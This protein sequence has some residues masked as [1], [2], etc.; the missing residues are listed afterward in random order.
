MNKN[1]IISPNVSCFF[2]FFL[3]GDEGQENLPSNSFLPLKRQYYLGM[4]GREWGGWELSTERELPHPR[5]ETR[6]D[7]QRFGLPGTHFWTFL[8]GAQGLRGTEFRASRKIA[9]HKRLEVGGR[10]WSSGPDGQG[11]ASCSVATPRVFSALS[12]LHLRPATRT[13]TAQPPGCPGLW[14]DCCLGELPA[15][16]RDEVC[17]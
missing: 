17:A 16:A 5:G 1:Q 13:I 6:Q 14:G 4:W 2:F 3:V 9:W 11:R 10:P 12:Q 15:A 7:G 8:Q